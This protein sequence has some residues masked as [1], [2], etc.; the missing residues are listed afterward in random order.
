MS[1]RP[2][3]LQSL[4]RLEIPESLSPADIRR[5]ARDAK[6]LYERLTEHPK[7]MHELLSAVLKG[8]KKSAQGGIRQL[9]LTEADFEAEEGGLLWLVVL[10]VLLY[11]TDAY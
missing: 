1:N 5:A 2:D 7:E 4:D 3:L 8:D 11:A 9:R 6:V 10:I